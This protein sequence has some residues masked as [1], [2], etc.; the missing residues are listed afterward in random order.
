MTLKEMQAAVAGRVNQFRKN[1]DDVDPTSTSEPNPDIPMPL[2]SLE[3]R[4]SLSQ[5]DTT[6]QTVDELKTKLNALIA[7]TDG[8]IDA[9]TF[10]AL[11]D[12][13]NNNLDQL[14]TRLS[15]KVKRIPLIPARMQ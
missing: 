13:T 12:E 3:D 1:S 2:S 10:T 5:P 8:I 6:T 7:T 15:N 9:L 14:K 11:V 4:T